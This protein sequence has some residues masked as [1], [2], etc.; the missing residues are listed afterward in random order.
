[1]KFALICT[2]VLMLC[3][4]LMHAQSGNIEG[5]VVDAETNE[6]LV[7]VNVFIQGTHVGAATNL[8]G[9]YR[10]LNVPPGRHTL[11][12][13]MIGYDPV[14][15][16]NVR[17]QIDQTTSIDV[18]MYET[19][20]DLG[21]VRIVA[22]RPIVQPDVSA[23]VN[24][25]EI[26]MID[27]MP[28]QTFEEVLSLQAGIEMGT[29]GIL[30]RGG[31]A[32]ETR[33]FVDGLSMDDERA[34]IPYTAVSLSSLQEVQVQTGG[35]SAEYGNI[36]SGL[37]NI[38]TREGQSERYSGRAIIHYGSPSPKNFG[39]S[40]YDPDSYFNRPYTDPAVMWTGTRDGEWDAYT[41]KQY[42]SF[43]G[44][45][46]IS[47]RTI[48]DGD[49]STDLTPEQA[50]RLWQWHRRRDG[51]IQKPDYVVDVGIG[52]PIPGLSS[53]AGNLRFYA[54]YFEE[55]DMFVFPLSRDS[56]SDR[57]GQI[58]IT[59]DITPSMKL[60]ITGLYG[61][62]HSVTPFEST[63]SPTG[64]IVRTQ[65]QV[66]NMVYNPAIIFMPQFY[67]PSSIYRNMIGFK[68]TNAVS[69]RTYYEV[70]FQHNA[71]Q[72]KTFKVADRDTAKI[73]EIFP[74][75]FVDEAPFGYS[76]DDQTGLDG[77]IIGG[78]M[79]LARDRTRNKT[80]L[81]SF[82]ITSQVE[83]HHQIKTGFDI[84]YNDFRIRS[85]SEHPRMDTWT[86]TLVYNVF[87]Y[88]I[89]A[90]VQD[91]MEYGGFIANIGVR[92]D[93]SDSNLDWFELEEF[94]RNLADGRGRHLE[95][96]APTKSINPV[97]N[98]SPRLGI[99]H[100]ITRNS[101]IYFN[102]GHFRSEAVSSLRFRIQREH[103]GRVTHLGNPDLGLEKTVAYEL[104]YEQNLFDLFLLRLAAYYKDV[105]GQPGWVSYTSFDG[106]VRY[107]VPEN[108]FYEDIRGFEATLEKRSG[109]WITGFV[110]YT[111]D[112]R[113]SGLFG[114]TQNFENP[115]DM[116]NYLRTNPG[117]SR[118]RP[119][120]YAR[121]NINIRTPVDFGP[122]FMGVPVL[123]NWSIS[124]LANWKAG[125]YT[126]YNPGNLPGVVDN[127]RWKDWYNLD[128]RISRDFRMMQSGF[129][130]FVNISNVFNFKH[131]NRAGFS[132]TFDWEDYLGSLRLPFRD[133]IF[134]GNDRIGDY[135]PWSVAF[136]PLEPNPDN[137]TDIAARN[138]ERIKNRSY[139]DNPSIRSLTFLN[140]R[141]ITFGI[142]IDL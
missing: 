114:F 104:G 19:I 55:R 39:P 48:E 100:P 20:F 67:S 77:M 89:G 95:E 129:Q 16:E 14:T 36:R 132:G 121:L 105:T 60:N 30:V 82:D 97:W 91:K 106:S 113:T 33:M 18:E 29:Q 134:R 117:Q 7:G 76:P 139:I 28:V 79:N 112:V 140:P 93:Y 35:F 31:S 128:M 37:V 64:T 40:V 120:P 22:E 73:H 116:R 50:Y 1:M 53:Y 13:T 88:R 108:N 130:I 58:R 99:S 131:M 119:L 59:S 122:K 80:T 6:K 138:K 103:S 17:V 56:Y 2:L 127:I 10:I 41:Q 110:N 75:Y 63:P 142:R 62:V 44:W 23:S 11:R 115:Q 87:P 102:Y 66:A 47:R 51:R 46:A 52:G 133:G 111:Y 49:P 57:H 68:L 26:G 65:E 21:E 86:R 118:P 70:R 45:N 96:E 5:T 42:P 141:Q 135:R 83:T 78:W 24:V 32:R 9:E 124:I 137:D 125:Q 92:F 136:D 85:F 74:G 15:V 109:R 71:N 8:D 3:P 126:T 12:I 101:K 27:Q 4:M 94:D 34:N 107:S 54:T 72:Y 43:E 61:E 38:V 84:T 123:G 90:F 25:V 98:I 81:F 69:A